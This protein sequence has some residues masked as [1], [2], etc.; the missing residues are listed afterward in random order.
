RVTGVDFSAKAIALARSLAAE[1]ELEADFVC[2]TVYD[3]PAALAGEFD[4]VFT[5]YGVLCW[6]PELTRWAEGVRPFLQPG[7]TFSLAEIHPF[8]FV[9]DDRPGT[10]ELRVAYPYCHTPEPLRWESQGSYA[11]RDARVEHTTSYLWNHGVGDTLN[12]LIGAGL[13]IEFV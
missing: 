5:S 4:I 3:L 13:R 1:L 7:G 11:D 10:T 9:F 2:S 6:L 12:A 8:S